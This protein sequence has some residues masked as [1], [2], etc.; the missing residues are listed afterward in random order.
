MLEIFGLGLSVIGLVVGILASAEARRVARISLSP[1]LKPLATIRL[2]YTCQRLGICRIIE[3][4]LNNVEKILHKLRKHPSARTIQILGL[5]IAHLK[6]ESDELF[7]D[8]LRHGCKFQFLLLDPTSPFMD[9]RTKQEN[10]DLKGEAEGFIKWLIEN[11][12]T[13]DYRYQIELRV[14]D[15]MPTMALTIINDNIMYQNPYTT[16]NRNNENPLIEIRKNGTLFNRFKGE[17]EKI[18]CHAKPIPLD[19]QTPR[20][21]SSKRKA[22]SKNDSGSSGS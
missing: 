22:H 15:L 18:W 10:P 14:Y 20:S 3:R 1:V 2:V 13:S 12:S 6:A 16:V 19:K 17:F 4:R 11:Y 9:Q 5:S 8:L 7:D 21:K